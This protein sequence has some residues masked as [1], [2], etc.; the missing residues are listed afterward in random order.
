MSKLSRKERRENKLK[1]PESRCERY[2]YVLLMRYP[3]TFSRIFRFF[4]RMRFSHASIGIGGANGPFFSYVLKGFR[5][6]LP[7]RYP[8]FNSREIPCRLY[9]LEVSEET[10]EKAK[11]ALAVHEKK[12]KL[13]GF[14]YTVVGVILSILR[15]I[16]KRNNRYFCSQFVSEL[17]EQV[18]A[19]PLQKHSALYL[20]DDFTK[21]QELDLCFTGNISEMVKS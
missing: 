12:S 11:K 8:T 17:L 2:V 15:I 1:R 9:K 21:M 5:R 6:E 7:E 19:V 18:S 10:Y 16:Y 14:R 3:D 20:P 4:T 13:L